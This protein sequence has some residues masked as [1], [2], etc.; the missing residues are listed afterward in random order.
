MLAWDYGKLVVGFVSNR[1]MS[2][3]GGTV[4]DTVANWAGF[5]GC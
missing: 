3:N 2:V 1:S 5:G 4:D